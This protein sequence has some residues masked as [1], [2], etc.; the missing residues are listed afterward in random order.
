MTK[1]GKPWFRKT[2]NGWYVW[3]LGKQ[4]LLAKGK[5]NK[6]EAFAQ[7]AALLGA[8]SADPPPAQIPVTPT[9]ARLVELYLSDVRG[10]IGDN[11]LV[12]YDC[13]LK[14]FVAKFGGSEAASLK[15]ADV[16]RWA[17][18][19]KWSK[20]TQR[21]ALTVANG[22]MKWAVRNGHLTANP[23]HDLKRPPGRS[24][25]PDILIDADLHLR[26]LEVV[27]PE[28][29]QFLLAVQA[30]GARP[31]EVAK[32]EARHVVW[33]ASCWM[34][35]DHKTAGK[36]GRE[37]VIHVPESVLAMCRDLAQQHPTGPLFR[38][39]RNEQWK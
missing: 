25:G 11:T 22:A 1:T 33:D 30:T 28:F 29:R 26:L 39:T 15:S 21:F 31:G 18:Q 12:S 4:V 24:R 34:L 16:E 17:L 20:T 6:P 32:V 27:S 14:P 36:T 13:V 23:L 10:R 9:V 37:R 3:H 38:N 19:R 2:H 5:E 8:K 7:F 35:A